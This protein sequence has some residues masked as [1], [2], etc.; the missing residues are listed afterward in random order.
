MSVKNVIKYYKRDGYSARLIQWL[1]HELWTIHAPLW[2]AARVK[3]SHNAILNHQTFRKYLHVFMW[4]VTVQ[5]WEFHN[6]ASWDTFQYAHMLSCPWTTFAA[7]WAGCLC[8]EAYMYT[9]SPLHNSKN[10]E[11]RSYPCGFWFSSRA[12]LPA[13][14]TPT[15]CLSSFRYDAHGE[16]KNVTT[17]SCLGSTV[18]LGYRHVLYT[19]AAL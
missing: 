8:L 7:F 16:I 14:I 18:A 11:F 2:T 3:H 17:Q 1:C 4:V 9:G 12:V 15:F 5:A 10:S 13:V 19:L 6:N